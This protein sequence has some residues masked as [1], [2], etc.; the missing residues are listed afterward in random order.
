MPDA[1]AAKGAVDGDV[2]TA[3]KHGLEQPPA[4]CMERCGLPAADALIAL[5]K[6]ALGT[7]THTT[8]EVS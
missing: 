2:A 8:N 7:T 3:V 1:P 5:G 4:L 6:V